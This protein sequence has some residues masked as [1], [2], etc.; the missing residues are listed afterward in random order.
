MKHILAKLNKY[1][2]KIRKAVNNQMIGNFH[3]VFKGSGLE[4]SDLRTYQ[5]GD[6]VRTIDW[7]TTAKGK[8]TF[9]KI[10]REEKEQTVF[11]LVDVSASQE[12][13]YEGNQKIDLAKEVF[14]VLAL[15][16]IKEASKVGIYAFSDQKELYMKASN[17]L[18]HGYELILK[19]FKIEPKSQKTNLTAAFIFALNLLKRR[20]LVIVISDFIDHD[21]EHHLKAI[22]QK[23]DLVVVHLADKR[24]TNLPKLG[25]VPVYDKE[26]K[27][28]VW[29]NTSAPS[30]RAAL[31]QTFEEKQ[32]KVEQ[33]CK[34]QNA[35][36]VLLNTSEDYVPKLIKLFK[37]RK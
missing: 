16:A 19:L 9:V 15:S 24:E 35:N 13:G 26:S 21:Y 34:Q 6:D 33:I 23:H 7:K 27:K 30:F 25:I 14:G 1:E 4:F 10:F 12:V 5:Y 31:N 3:S 20:S 8:G 17:G 32:K 37:V 29:L 2:I 36:Y 28:M 11:F 22:A 18:K